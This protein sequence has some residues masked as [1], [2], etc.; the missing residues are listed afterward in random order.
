MSYRTLEEKRFTAIKG[1]IQR[2][3]RALFK[4]PLVELYKRIIPI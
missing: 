1:L 2:Q 4:S 3:N